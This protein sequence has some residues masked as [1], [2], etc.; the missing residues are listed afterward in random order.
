MWTSRGTLSDKKA[1][2]WAKGAPQ[3][4]LLTT[5]RDEFVS[6]GHHVVADLGNP[7]NGG[8]EAGTI[9]GFFNK[10]KQSSNVPNMLELRDR[11]VLP[12]QASKYNALL[13]QTVLP[14]PTKYNMVRGVSSASF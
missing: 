14:L 9:S 3:V 12:M 8:I 11:S 4:G 2:I 13:L 7:S 5:S 1:S 10:G 6:L